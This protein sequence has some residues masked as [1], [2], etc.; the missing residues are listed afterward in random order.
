MQRFSSRFGPVELTQERWQH[1]I[2]FHPEVRP[3]QKYFQRTLAQPKLI[4]RSKTDP[5]VFI[6]YRSIPGQK[7]LA[8][9]IKTNTRNFVL[10]AYITRTLGI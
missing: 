2:I 10:T 8:I 6:C 7:F 4:K 1:I 5:K 3:V 9:V